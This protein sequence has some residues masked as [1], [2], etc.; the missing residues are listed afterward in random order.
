MCFFL[1][2]QLKNVELAKELVTEAE[3]ALKAND[4]VKCVEKIS[5][6]IRISLKSPRLRSIRAKCHFEK[7]EVEEGI[8]DLTWVQLFNKRN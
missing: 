1:L 7:G 2:I 8:R 3:N 6:A 5:D 4:Y